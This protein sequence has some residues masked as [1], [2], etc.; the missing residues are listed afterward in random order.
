M[1]YEVVVGNGEFE[2]AK[3]LMSANKKERKVRRITFAILAVLFFALA[4]FGMCSK[5][6][7]PVSTSISFGASAVFIWLLIISRSR[8]VNNVPLEYKPSRVT[9]E[10]C[11]NV[12]IGESGGQRTAISWKRLKSW[13]ESNEFLYIEFNRKQFVVVNKEQL[14]ERALKEIEGFLSQKSKRKDVLCLQ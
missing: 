2:R 8:K 5:V 14:S 7:E 3:I 6:M 4:M 9:Y 10:F 11:E 1:K 13:G 12:F